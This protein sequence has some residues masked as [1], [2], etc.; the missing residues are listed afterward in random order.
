[1]IYIGIRGVYMLVNT[2]II[3]GKTII[4]NIDS[5]K[6]FMVSEKNFL[7]GTV[8]P[9]MVSK[10]KLKKHYLEESFKMIIDKIKYLSRLTLE[11]IRKRF[12]MSKFSQE[13]GVIC[14]FLCDFFCVPHSERWEFKHS[15]NKHIKYERE[16]A[17]VA[18]EFVPLKEKI[19]IFDNE[20]IESFILDLHKKYKLKSS[21]ENDVIF[22]NYACNSVVDYVFDSILF[23]TLEK[24]IFLTA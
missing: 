3:I 4:N 11:D 5:D 10:Y 23:N 19:K 15:M 1:M 13:L 14:H 9:D 18:K 24:E 12:S 7:Y 21:Y 16:L 22:A 17:I 20:P 6:L 2:H 8:K